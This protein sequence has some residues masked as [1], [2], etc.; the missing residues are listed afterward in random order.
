MVVVAAHERP[1]IFWV[2]VLAERRRAG[3]IGEEDCNEFP[4]FWHDFSY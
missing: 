3:D 1:D 4:L 2:E